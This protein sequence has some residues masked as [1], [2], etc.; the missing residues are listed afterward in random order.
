MDQVFGSLDDP[1]RAE[2][3]GLLAQQIGN[4]YKDDKRERSRLR[5]LLVL[6]PID[7]GHQS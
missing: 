7:P 2:A 1:E 4:R 6:R 5:E 3:L